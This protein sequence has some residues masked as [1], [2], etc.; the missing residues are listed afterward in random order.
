[1]IANNC[2]VGYNEFDAARKKRGKSIMRKLENDETGDK[3]FNMGSFWGEDLKKPFVVFDRSTS[4][5]CIYCGNEATTREHCPPQSFFELPRPADLPTVPACKSCNNGFSSDENYVKHFLYDLF[6]YYELN[7]DSF[8]VPNEN[9]RSEVKEARE[10]V[11]RFIRNPFFDSKMERIFRKIALGHVCYELSETLFLDEEQNMTVQVSYGIR[12][13][14]DKKVWDGIGC[15]EDITNDILPELGSR[16]YDNI[17]V[18]ESRRIQGGG[19]KE[20]KNEFRFMK[21]SSLQE[22]NYKYIAFLRDDK[23]IVKM[24]YRDFFYVEVV[25]NPNP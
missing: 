9:E 18:V 4:M 5:R 8:E 24:L 16:A 25:F 12:Q 23:I 15:F 1:M 20:F 10:A 6:M 7:D 11:Q 14:F 3:G 13:M 22:G 17:Y 19:T 21:W 2:D